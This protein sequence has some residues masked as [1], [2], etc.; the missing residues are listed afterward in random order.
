MTTMGGDGSGEETKITAVK[1]TQKSTNPTITAT[2]TT[3][4]M[5]TTTTMATKTKRVMTTTMMRR[6]CQQ[7]LRRV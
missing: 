5:A 7:Q 2:A 3:T 1:Q 6:W 4:A